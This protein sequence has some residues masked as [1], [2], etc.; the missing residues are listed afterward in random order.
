MNISLCDDNAH[1][2]S[3][4]KNLVLDWAAQSGASVFVCE[5]PSAEALLFSYPDS[6]PDIL[7]L[8]I[9]MPGMNGIELAKKLR[10]R[11]ETAQIV[12]ITGY[13]DFI[14]EGYD[15]SALHYLLKPVS[16]DK[17]FEVL[18]RAYKAVCEG[19]P[20]ETVVFR[21]GTETLRYKLSDIEYIAAL[22]HSTVLLSGGRTYD[23]SVPISEVETALCEGFIRCHRSYIVNLKYVSAVSGDNLTMDSGTK[24]PVARAARKIVTEAFIHYYRR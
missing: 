6:P 16:S 1:E 7:L 15:V 24:I 12:F 10:A 22:G 4:I 14:S 21:A 9:E 13:P 3:Y 18:D 2:R 23:L 8:D 17:L 19:K 11:A 20:P 5:Y